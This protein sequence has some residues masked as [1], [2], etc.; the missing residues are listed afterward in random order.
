[1]LRC[2]RVRARGAEQ[3]RRRL[4]AARPVDVRAWPKN[5][6]ADSITVSVSVGCGWMVS[7]RSVAVAP[8]SIASTPSAISS[9][10]PGP[11]R[12]TP[13]TR[14]VSGS[15]I[16]FVRPSV[17]SSV[18][19]RPDAPHGNFAIVHPAALLLRLV[20]GQPAPRDLGIGEDDRRN[21][22]AARTTTFSPAIASTRRAPRATPCARASARRRRRR[23]RRSTARAVRRCSSTMMKPRCVDLDLRLVEARESSSSAGGRP[24]TSTRSNTCSV[25]LEPSPSK[26][27][28][29]AVLPS[30]F[31]A[32]TFVSSSTALASSARRAWRGRRRDRDRRPAAGPASSRRR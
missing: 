3:P 22:R 6:S 2:G 11:T 24:T 21:R 26:V 31:I 19:A 7:L 23:W 25:A 12:P 32:T 1:M 9:P 4:P 10:A 16:S 29:D 8:I 30:A 28:R 17:R 27:T 13:S 20:F 14:S 18:I 15:R 5:T